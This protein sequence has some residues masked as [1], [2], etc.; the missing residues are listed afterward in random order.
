MAK[1]KKLIFTGEYEKIIPNFG[2]YKPGDE[3]DFDKSLL[4]TGLFREKTEKDGDE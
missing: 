4:E 3:V 2:V 1:K